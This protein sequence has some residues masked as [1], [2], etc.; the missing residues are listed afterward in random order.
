MN[1]TQQ[2]Q[3]AFTLVELLV[4]I[5]I[6]GIL[7]S[8]LLTALAKSK[9]EA[10]ETQCLNNVKQLALADQMYV[11]ETGLNVRYNDPQLPGYDSSWPITD[12]MGALSNYGEIDQTR[13][14]PATH[15]P[16]QTPNQYAPGNA[17]TEWYSGYTQP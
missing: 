4:V 5:A 2:S 6:I 11:T 3:R 13:I 10:Q 8:L 17:D 9:K 15:L 1:R 12:W 14:C 16:S 7:A